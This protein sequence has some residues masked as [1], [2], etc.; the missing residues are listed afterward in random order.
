LVILQSMMSPKIDLQ[1]LGWSYARQI[2]NELKMAKTSAHIGSSLVASI[3]IMLSSF[4]D[5][6]EL[7][8]GIL[9][10]RELDGMR[11][12]VCDQ[13]IHLFT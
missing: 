4:E 5:V 10:A 12:N 8:E 7:I 3:E 6:V 1:L 9:N 2:W 11:D 13:N